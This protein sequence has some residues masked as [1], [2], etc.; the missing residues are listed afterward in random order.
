MRP[1]LRA[2]PF[3]V[4]ANMVFLFILHELALH[5][6]SSELCCCFSTA[7]MGE[8]SKTLVL[9][10]LSHD[11]REWPSNFRAWDRS[12][13]TTAIK[14]PDGKWVT[15][16]PLLKIA[17]YLD[18]APYLPAVGPDDAPQDP[19]KWNTELLL[20]LAPKLPKQFVP[21][22]EK[23]FEDATF[24]DPRI[25]RLLGVHLSDAVV[26][27]VADSQIGRAHV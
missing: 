21:V 19:T 13:E 15:T 26:E 24:Q 18:K 5:P 11:F 7:T 4:F 22:L 1:L 12:T 20:Q 27:A 8:T 25:H 23:A 6:R 2:L 10:K 3:C 14:T 9:Q 16:N 17:K